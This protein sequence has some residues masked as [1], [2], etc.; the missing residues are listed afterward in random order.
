VSVDVGPTPFVSKEGSVLTGKSLKVRNIVVHDEDEVAMWVAG[1]GLSDGRVMETNVVS[2]PEMLLKMMLGAP[3]LDI[4]S[5]W[6]ARM[7]S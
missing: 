3:R 1:R 5:A 2:V 4:S 6:A 7:R